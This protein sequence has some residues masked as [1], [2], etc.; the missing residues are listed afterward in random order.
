MSES[1]IPDKVTPEQMTKDKKAKDAKKE[2]R[3]Q[4][5]QA[6]NQKLDLIINKIDKLCSVGAFGCIFTSGYY[7]N[8]DYKSMLLC[9][10]SGGFLVFIAWILKK[11]KENYGIDLTEVVKRDGIKKAIR[12]TI[13]KEK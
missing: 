11:V 1:L 7:L 2:T 9:A 4:V 13:V 10:G 5:L 6:M 12:N 3:T 8:S